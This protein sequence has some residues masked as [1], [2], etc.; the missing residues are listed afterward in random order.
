LVLDLNDDGESSGRI[1]LQ[2]LAAAAAAATAA[3]TA[4]KQIE[5]VI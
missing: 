1:P 3:V 2:L 5:E 4:T